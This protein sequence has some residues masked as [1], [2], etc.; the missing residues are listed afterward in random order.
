[1][2]KTLLAAATALMATAA[3]AG[4][5]PAVK[6]ASPAKTLSTSGFWK[7]DFYER[8]FF[9]GVP[10]C[11]MQPK[12]VRSDSSTFAV[13]Y[14]TVGDTFLHLYKPG[15]KIP[16]GTKV[17]VSMAFD[18]AMWTAEGFAQI[19]QEGH[20]T[21]GGKSVVNIKID[22]ELKA[23]FTSSSALMVTFAKGSEK[24]WSFNLNGSRGALDVFALCVS[25][26]VKSVPQPFDRSDA[27]KNEPAQEMPP[28]DSKI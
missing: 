3:F 8:N 7:V 9:Y 15:W 19:I 24:P 1:M 4:P 17:S 20:R 22:D 11:V 2:N 13:K 21:M 18:E 10:Q 5:S 6:Q 26:I 12:T 25:D 23:L 28:N 16:K 14:T 27:P